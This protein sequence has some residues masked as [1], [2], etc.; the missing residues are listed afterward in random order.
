METLVVKTRDDI[1]D[2]ANVISAYSKK[3]SFSKII[4]SSSWEDKVKG[5]VQ[6]FTT[7]RGRFEFELAMY[8]GHGVNTANEKLVT[9]EEK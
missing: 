3:P 6:V 7:R 9:I 5:F 8:V 4:H 1:T 2:C